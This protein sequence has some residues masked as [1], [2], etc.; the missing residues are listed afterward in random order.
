MIRGL[1]TASAGLLEDERYQ[2]LLANN[3]ANMETPGFKTTGGEAMQFPEQLL[4]MMN[5]GDTSGPTIGKLGTGVLF[6]EGVPLFT[7]GQVAQT[8]RPLDVA[9]V[10]TTPSGTYAAVATAGLP[11]GSATG[12]TTGPAGAALGLQSVLG[13]VTAGAGGR[14]SMNGQPLAV[15]TPDGKPIVG[16][17]AMKNPAYQ[18]VAL[19]AS[20]GKPD[21]DAN[22]N[23][24]Y[25]FVNAKNQVVGAPGQPGF[26]AAALR[27]GNEDDMGLHSFFAV[28]YQSPEGP[29]GIAL[30]HNGSLSTNSAHELVDASGSALL[31]VGQ[32]G[33]PIANGRIVVNGSYH[34]TDLFAPDGSPVIDS[35]GQPSYK[36]VDTNG[37]AIAGAKLG[38]VDAD[39]TQLNP[40]GQSE[41]MVGNSLTAPQVLANLR[42]GTGQLK[43]GQLERSNVDVTSTLTQM[44]AVIAQYQANQEVVKT[45]DSLLQK[46][47]DDVGRVNA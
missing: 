31:P 14:L 38:T 25:V 1:S 2:Q 17:Y 3:L 10:D 30:T 42:A 7:E 34:G 8:G 21:Y 19:Y 26:D 4:Q 45:E 27:V 44:T 28:A 22:G 41:F 33:L 37:N 36:V 11:I 35:A 5:Y 46:A 6:Q 13:N 16:L 12:A 40:L 32:N 18:G 23:P 47:V 20:D 39:V 29:S 43:P 9:I 24:S 15:V